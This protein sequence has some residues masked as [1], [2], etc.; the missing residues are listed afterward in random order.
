[1]AYALIVYDATATSAGSVV[2]AYTTSRPWSDG[3]AK[4]RGLFRFDRHE[5]AALGRARAFVLDARR[6]AYVPI[7]PTMVPSSRQTRPGR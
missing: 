7:N 1:L 4:P 3:I 5:A 6:L 2:A